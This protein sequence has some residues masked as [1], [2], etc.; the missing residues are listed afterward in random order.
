MNTEISEKIPQ[1][2]LRALASTY[3]LYFASQIA[4]WNVEGPNFPQ[5]HDMFGDIYS[6]AFDSIDLVAEQ[7]RQ[8]D[9]KIPETFQEI[10]S[11]SSITA[12]TD[13]YTKQLLDLQEKLKEQWDK[14]AVVAEAAED[15]STV[16]LA[17]KRAGVH[18]KFA[19]MLR[20][21]L[22]ENNA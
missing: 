12:S 16:D 18:S 2:L 3:T 22:K 10:I 5:L 21:I 17:G 8:Y 7:I 11:H 6:D 15:S 13:T 14:I 19:W 4:H 20:S 9:V 1:I